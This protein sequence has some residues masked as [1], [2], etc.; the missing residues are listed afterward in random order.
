MLE[1]KDIYDVDFLWTIVGNYATEEG[2][3]LKFDI[4]RSNKYG[5]NHG[6][7]STF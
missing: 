7:K 5:N 3:N 6:W 4:C 2:I 1:P